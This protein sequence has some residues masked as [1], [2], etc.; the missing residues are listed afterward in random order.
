MSGNNTLMIWNKALNYFEVGDDYYW[1][2]ELEHRQK[3]FYAIILGNNG[4]NII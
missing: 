2:K 1:T 4:K 3:K